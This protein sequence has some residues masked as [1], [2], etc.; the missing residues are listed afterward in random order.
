ML[1]LRQDRMDVLFISLGGAAAAAGHM[2]RARC[3]AW[4]P[5]GA[6]AVDMFIWRC[7]DGLPARVVAWH[8][9]VQAVRGRA[10]R[11]QLNC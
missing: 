10:V 7:W 2:L 8:Q 4:A 5:R 11:E 3:G 1:E 6:L 9:I